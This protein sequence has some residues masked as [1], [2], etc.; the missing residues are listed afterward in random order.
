MNLK[1]LLL[2]AGAA[3]AGAAVMKRRGQVPAPVAQ[4]ASTAAET[5]QRAVQNATPG[6]GGDEQPQERYE[7][8]IEAGAQ[9]PAETGGPPSSDA[10]VT[11]AE[12]VVSQPGGQ[13]N[14]PDHAP[15]EGS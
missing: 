11:E 14:T 6:D 7:P 1:P 8:P 10:T 13:L 15:P 9:P 12:P 2:L 3:G 5:V 4:A